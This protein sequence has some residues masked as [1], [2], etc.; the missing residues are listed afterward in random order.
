[1]RIVLSA[2]ISA[3]FSIPLAFAA[4]AAG[5]GGCSAFDWPLDVEQTWFSAD[6]KESVASGSALEGIPEKAFALKLD[7]TSAVKFPIAPTGQPK[8]KDGQTFGG[9]VSFGNIT[10]PGIYQVTLSGAGWV[11]IIQNGAALKPVAHTGMKDCPAIRKSVRFDL[12]AGDLTLEVSGSS[13]A[14]ITFAIRQLQ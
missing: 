2:I 9:S 5:S 4:A 3:L 8:A 14:S 7:A 11:D 6:T 13:E 1:M 12:S 10:K